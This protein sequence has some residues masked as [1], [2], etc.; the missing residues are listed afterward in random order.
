MGCS[1]Y[2]YFYDTWGDKFKT[3]SL[4]KLI[5]KWCTDDKGRN[6]LYKKCGEERYPDFKLYK[7]IAR[8]VH[9]HVPQKQVDNPLF[10]KFLTSRKKIKKK[11]IIDIDTLPV[12]TS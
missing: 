11:R 5:N 10:H 6:I 7:M 4:P 8:T 2:D 12:Y 9:N 1:L 3:H